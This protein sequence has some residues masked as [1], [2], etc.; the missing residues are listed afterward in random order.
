MEAA[1]G[2]DVVL[3]V[4][5]LNGKILQNNHDATRRAATQPYPAALAPHLAPRPPPVIAD[6]EARLRHL[7][8]ARRILKPGGKLFVFI[9]SGCYPERGSGVQH[10][11]T[12][13]GSCQNNRWTSEYVP[14]VEAVFGPG[15]VYA[16]V[17][18]NS[19]VAVKRP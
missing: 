17:N 2:C 19:I 15:A 12:A 4:S 13:R 3:S 18:A 11:D 6:V 5:V 16:D 10:I 7:V 14:E 1:G 9:W 8:L